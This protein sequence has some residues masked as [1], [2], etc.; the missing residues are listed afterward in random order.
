M[1]SETFNWRLGMVDQL[2]AKLKELGALDEKRGYSPLR[3]FADVSGDRF[4]RLLMQFEVESLTDFLSIQARVM[5]DEWAGAI[6][7][8]YHELIESGRRE[9]N[10]VEGRATGQSNFVVCNIRPEPQYLTQ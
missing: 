7:A 4:R 9:T 1:I 8:G 2:V 3:H 6:M 10:N 5:T